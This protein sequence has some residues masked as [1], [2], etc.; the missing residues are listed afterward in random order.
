MPQ[1]SYL[2]RTALALLCA[3]ALVGIACTATPPPAPRS[4]AP[5]AGGPTIEF[6]GAAT[7]ATD[8]PYANTRIGGLSG[9]VRDPA[10]GVYY[11]LADHAG[12]TGPARYYTLEVDLAGGRLA[13][14]GARV[15]AVSELFGTGGEPLPADEVD[16]E[17]IALAE[18]GGLWVS[19]EGRARDGVAPFVDLFGRDRRRLRSLRVPDHFLPRTAAGGTGDGAEVV[20]GVRHNKVFEG[21][22]RSP[23]GRYLWVGTE[24]ALVQDGPAA[25][26]AAGSRARL[27]R[28][29]LDDP[30]AAPVELVYP[31]GP[32]PEPSPTGGLEVNGLVELLALDDRRLLALE[33]SWVAGGRHGVLLHLVDPAGATEVTGVAS[34][35]EAPGPVMPVAKTLLLDL[36]CLAGPAGRPLHLDNLEGMAW[37]PDL[38]G[39]DRTLLL[40]SDDNFNP[41]EQVTQIL[42]FRV[43]G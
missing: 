4:A 22:A 21:L 20:Y 38:P 13:P 3:A 12:D 40:V 30:E 24:D 2:P 19:S 10:R 25:S 29:D 14:D 9:L 33:R 16:P 28:W 8:R 27:L 17:G 5:A 7:L 26:P 31:L 42:A 18:E 37:G 32:V 34:F 35:A 6:L 15:V 39:G 43:S 41:D 1:S 23:D 36:G 11:A